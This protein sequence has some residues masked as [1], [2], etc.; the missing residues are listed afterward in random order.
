MAYLYLFLFFLD[1]PKHAWDLLSLFVIQRELEITGTTN[2][3]IGAE[4][5]MKI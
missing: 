3:R 2:L 4:T 5:L 1:K